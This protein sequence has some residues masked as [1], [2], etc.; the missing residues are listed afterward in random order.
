MATKKTLPPVKMRN[1][2]KL[3][4]DLPIQSVPIDSIQLPASQPRHYFDPDKMTN[5]VE[6]VR[7][8]GVLEPLLVRPLSG[9][10]FELIAGERRLRA[11]G[12]VGLELVPVVSKDFTDTEALQVSL[13]ENLQREDLNPVEETEGVLD[14][15]AITLDADR[16]SVI[17]LLHRSKNAR[18]RGRELNHNVMVQL[19]A[20][21]KTLTQLGK[22]S[23]DSFRSNRLPL[24]ALP[25]D[26]LESL[27]Q[28]KLEYTKA[29]AISRI[30]DEAQR[31]ELLQ[32]AIVENLSLVQ[33]RSKARSLNSQQTL[34]RQS[35]VLDRYAQI[36]KRLRNGTLLN[37]AA[38]RKQVSD[39]LG[40]LEQLLEGK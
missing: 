30:K 25:K 28:G 18:V 34:T 15:L 3:L 21:E 40:E 11:A 35:K 9:G 13:L 33:I 8:F 29:I 22:F 23:V 32:E 31:A 26:I 36:G 19:E 5:L 17:S 2:A 14:L 7:S 6:S 37:D 38:K 39:L 1:K 27:R 20:V 16:E 4:D 24:L 10:Q 12:E